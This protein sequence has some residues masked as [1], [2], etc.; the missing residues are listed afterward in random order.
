MH[1][2]CRYLAYFLSLCCIT[3]FLE[4]MKLS[5]KII[6]KRL[7]IPRPLIKTAL[8]HSM[9]VFFFLAIGACLVF[10]TLE[11]KMS[12]ENSHFDQQ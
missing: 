10:V 8:N 4:N 7:A 2:M 3:D 1:Q 9:K 11:T 5:K 12:C 6:R